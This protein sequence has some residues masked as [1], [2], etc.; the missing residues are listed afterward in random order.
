ML[1]FS[2]SIA[3][4]LTITN[5]PASRNASQIIELNNRLS[6]CK[7]ALEE[8]SDDVIRL[9][10]ALDEISEEEFET[11]FDALSELEKENNLKL[12]PVV[13]VI[14]KHINA[15]HLNNISI[16]TKHHTIS[17]Y[18]TGDGLGLTWKIEKK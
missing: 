14:H 2:I 1:I 10:K 15:M 17:G 9:Q 4:N 12:N 6:D 11:L 13:R 5:K 16:N 3:I 18:D 8:N 7:D